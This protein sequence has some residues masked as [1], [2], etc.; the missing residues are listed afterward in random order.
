MV[1]SLGLDNLAGFRVLV[2]FQ[3]ALTT[4]A[5]HRRFGTFPCHRI[6]HGDYI[7]QGVAVFCQEIA[8]LGFKLNFFLQLPVA[9]ESFQALLLLRDLG[10]LNR[11]EFRFARLIMALILRCADS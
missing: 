10:L 9:F 2:A 6:K 1:A 5:F 4:C 11:H 8:Q 7:T 3:S